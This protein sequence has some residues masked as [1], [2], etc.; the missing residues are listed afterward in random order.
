MVLNALEMDPGRQWKGVW[1]W[2]SDQ[3]LE[4]FTTGPTTLHTGVTFREFACLARCNGLKVISKR[5]DRT[6]VDS[7]GST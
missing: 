4:C 2:Y 1:R 7:S 3:N 5:A 6:L